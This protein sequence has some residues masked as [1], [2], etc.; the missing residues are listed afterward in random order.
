MCST[1]IIPSVIK[2]PIALTPNI[3]NCTVHSNLFIW[4]PRWDLEQTR[5]IE[6]RQYLHDHPEV[7]HW[8]SVDDLNMGKNGEPWKDEWA[9]GNFVLTP[10]SSEG[11]RKRSH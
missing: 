9:I 6:I 7:T 3:Q 10:K 5:T 2:R 1:I 11:I 8:V 4:S